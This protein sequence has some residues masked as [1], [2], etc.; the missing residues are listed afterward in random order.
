MCT[1]ISSLSSTQGDVVT[2]PIVT[3][4]VQSC[5]YEFQENAK[6]NND[7]IKIEIFC[8]AGLS[9]ISFGKNNQICTDF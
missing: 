3:V 4:T 1:G 9:P 7:A 8:I 5:A 2:P 6:T